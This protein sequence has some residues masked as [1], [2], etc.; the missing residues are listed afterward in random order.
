MHRTR[1]LTMSLSAAQV[2]PLALLDAVPTV[3]TV[4]SVERTVRCCN[5]STCAHSSTASTATSGQSRSPKCRWT[6]W[7]ELSINSTVR[8][9]S[10][11]IDKTTPTMLTSAPGCQ[12]FDE[13]HGSVDLDRFGQ[14]DPGNAP[15]ENAYVLAGRDRPA[16]HECIV[17]R[18]QLAAANATAV[19]QESACV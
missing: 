19:A 3:I 6:E 10:S 16:V 2:L 12:R 1:R 5:T 4:T 13:R 8:F 11:T 17:V 18:L 14:M 9:V 15:L 7:L